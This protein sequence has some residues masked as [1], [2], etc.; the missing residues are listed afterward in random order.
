MAKLK[1]SYIVVEMLRCAT[2]ENSLAFL[3]T[4]NREQPNGSSNSTP[5]YIPKRYEH[6]CPNKNIY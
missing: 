5:W 4:L 3:S 2:V 1:L 6:T